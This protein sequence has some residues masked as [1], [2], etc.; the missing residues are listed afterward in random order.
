MHQNQASTSHFRVQLNA[1]GPSITPSHLS[2]LHINIISHHS[3]TSF[4]KL[5]RIQTT[6]R[7]DLT[8]TKVQTSCGSEVKH[9]TEWC[10]HNNFDLPQASLYHQHHQGWTLFRFLRIT[11]SM[12]WTNSNTILKKLQQR[13]I[14]LHQHSSVTIN[15]LSHP[16]EWAHYLHHRLTLQ[17]RVRCVVH[18]GEKIISCELIDF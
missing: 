15:H 4:T 10:D 7:L 12:K 16:G 9:P 3:W 11:I 13:Q 2:Y 17:S 5:S 6:Q 1:A 8:C 14:F 18:S